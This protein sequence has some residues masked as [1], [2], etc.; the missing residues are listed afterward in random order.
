MIKPRFI[1]NIVDEHMVVIV[2]VA[3]MG[4]WVQW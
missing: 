2:I 3:I 1:E 4:L